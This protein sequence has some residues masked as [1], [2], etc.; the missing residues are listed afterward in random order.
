MF[1]AKMIFS[2]DFNF[3][4]TDG[5]FERIINNMYDISTILIK[6]RQLEMQ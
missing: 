6:V 3:Y 5:I 4:D 2:I 1:K